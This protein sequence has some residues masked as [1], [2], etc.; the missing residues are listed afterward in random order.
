VAHGSVVLL[1]AAGIGPVKLLRIA[2]TN[3]TILWALSVFYNYRRSAEAAVKRAGLWIGDNNVSLKFLLA[4]VAFLLLQ[5]TLDLVFGLG[6]FR[7]RA[8][9]LYGISV[10]SALYLPTLALGFLFFAVIAM[11]LGALA[12]TFGEEYGWRGFLQDQLAGIGM[13]QA[14]LLIG[15]IWGIWHIPI[16]LTGVHTYP[17][18]AAGFATS[19]V[20]FSLWGVVQTYVVLK[21]GS[22][23]PAAF[24]HG[25]VNSVYGFIRIYIVSPDD[26]IL[27]FGLGIYGVACL[28]LVVA[29]I[30]RDPVWTRDRLESGPGM[31]RG[32]EWPNTGP[33]TERHDEY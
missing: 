9:S 10:P 12:I 20:F 28:A 2:G 29:A 30:W 1:S 11:P 21:S 5:G 25:L 32:S 19:F 31:A 3:L 16:L 23:W 8:D 17:P 15:L 13:R 4:I 7:P 14:G 18:T 6:D 22:I 26:K 27:S 33:N 24:L